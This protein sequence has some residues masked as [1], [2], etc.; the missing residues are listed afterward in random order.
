M[1]NATPVPVGDDDSF[2]NAMA[3]EDALCEKLRYTRV[4]PVRERFG[5]GVGRQIAHDSSF[6]TVSRD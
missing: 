3:G 4:S 5:P 6:P 2:G 1:P